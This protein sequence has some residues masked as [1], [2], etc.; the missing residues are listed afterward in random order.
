MDLYEIT[1]FCTKL[2]HKREKCVFIEK[3]AKNAVRY[4]RI[5]D[6]PLACDVME[7]AC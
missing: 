4:L 1:Y 5:Q 2:L 6:G 7:V 3:H